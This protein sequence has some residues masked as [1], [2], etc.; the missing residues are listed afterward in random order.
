MQ[1]VRHNIRMKENIRLIF[2]ALWFPATAAAFAGIMLFVLTLGEYWEFF[3]WSVG[4]W[5]I[6][7]VTVI[8]ASLNA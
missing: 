6:C 1:N 2:S 7:T 8:T 3:L 4:A 5:I